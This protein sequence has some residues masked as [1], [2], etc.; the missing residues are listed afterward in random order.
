LTVIECPKCGSKFKIEKDLI[1]KESLKMRCSVCS[2]VFIHSLVE[3]QPS[4]DDFD[5]LIGTKDG[6]L[7]E[8]SLSD[9]LSRSLSEG[10]PLDSGVSEITESKEEE[11]LLTEE[12]K[13][14]EDELHPDSVIREIDTILG[15]S[16]AIPAE[17]ELP[18]ET[19][20]ARR[21]SFKAKAVVALVALAVVCGGVLGAKLLLPHLNKDQKELEAPA[22]EKGPFFSI[23]DG[24]VT[25]EILTNDS[26]GAVLV[27]KGVIRKLTAKPL[28][29][30]LVEARI[31]DPANTLMESRSA[32]A[33]IVPESSELMRQKSA[34]IDTLLTAEPR[35]LGVLETS[36]D[37]PFAVAF[38]GKSAREGTAFKV[39]VKEF[40]WK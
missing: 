18:P 10:I 2:H 30:I 20:G 3:K 40:H 13:P 7:T 34:D 32:Y 37:I 9:D 21:M 26:E 16:E 23:P 36:Q 14:K 28:K 24:S 17:D 8:K 6:E 1:S 12:E 38:F 27:V 31:Y 11:T 22:L 4:E 25:Y 29:S 33:G 19:Q 35:T 39:E 15:A 5:L